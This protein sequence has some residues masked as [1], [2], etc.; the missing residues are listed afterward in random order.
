MRFSFDTNA[1]PSDTEYLAPVAFLRSALFGIV[2]KRGRRER[3]NGPIAH[4]Q[5]FELRFDGEVLDQHDHDLWLEAVRLAREHGM[6]TNVRF[7]ARELL[8]ALGW[9]ISGKSVA[10]LKAG[11]KRL[12]KSSI[13]IEGPGFYYVGHLIDEA[14]IK[15]S[16]EF[17][18][19]LSPKMASLFASGQSVLLNVDERK[20]I[21]GSLAKWL[22][23]FIVATPY[24]F[25]MPIAKLRE[26]SG[27]AESE[28]YRFRSRLKAALDEIQAV[29]VI[30]G[31]RFD[32]VNVYIT[33][34]PKLA[35][36]PA[37]APAARG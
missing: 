22:H 14:E 20:R 9:D 19:R 1:W 12:V 37:T 11:L 18:F 2:P 35:L 8:R 15:N 29:G 10:R 28:R 32:R 5:G 34:P 6:G 23:P 21:H 25:P 7:A 27:W 26:A 36:A 3:V 33:L 16:S 24:A 4:V 17:Y 31:F 30:T 13:E